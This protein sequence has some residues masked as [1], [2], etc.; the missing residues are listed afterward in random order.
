MI[1]QGKVFDSVP[2]GIPR[3]KVPALQAI[4]VRHVPL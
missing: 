3:E 1:T 2:M 4:G